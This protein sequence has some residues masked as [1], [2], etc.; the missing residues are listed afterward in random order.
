[1]SRSIGNGHRAKSVLRKGKHQLALTGRA[2][3]TGRRKSLSG[4]DEVRAR[5]GGGQTK[6]WKANSGEVVDQKLT[7]WTRKSWSEK[8]GCRKAFIWGGRDLLRPILAKAQNMRA[9]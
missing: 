4:D 6:R 7:P 3:T 5:R 2:G 9:V 1:L 8:G